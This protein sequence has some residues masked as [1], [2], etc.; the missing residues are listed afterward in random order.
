MYKIDIADWFPFQFI[1]YNK[2]NKTPIRLFKNF[3]GIDV[4]VIHFELVDNKLISFSNDILP[5]FV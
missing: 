3:Q 2:I 4:L 5:H 1:F